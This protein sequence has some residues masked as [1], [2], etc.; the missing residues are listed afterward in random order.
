MYYCTGSG[1]IELQITKKQAAIGSHSGA[2]DQ[3][4]NYLLQ[5][6][7]IKRQFNKI[8]PEI[9]AKELGEYGA[10]SEED[11]QDHEENKARLL[12]IACGD[13]LEELHSKQKN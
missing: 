2:C 9:I 4:I 7:A 13:I 10:W 3:D 1:R 6:P 8:S 11:L 5:L 12:W